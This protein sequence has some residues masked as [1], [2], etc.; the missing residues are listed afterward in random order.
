[1]EVTKFFKINFKSKEEF[2]DFK[3]ELE[4]RKVDFSIEDFALNVFYEEEA[5]F[6][7]E[8]E[9]ETEEISEKNYQYI[10]Q[11]YKDQMKE[12]FFD[13]DYVL[14]ND[15]IQDIV[16]D[17]MKKIE[18]EIYKIHFNN[19]DELNKFTEQFKDIS[20]VEGN[21]V[22]LNNPYIAEELNR[23]EISNCRY[24]NVLNKE[25]EDVSNN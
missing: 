6:R 10:M 12:D 9:L 17:I 13:N 18:G 15:V 22:I 7:I 14:D 19:I 24:I 25:Y 4:G 16:D 11:K 1:M 2:R 8:L 3:K 21:K 5:K 23:Y 20:K